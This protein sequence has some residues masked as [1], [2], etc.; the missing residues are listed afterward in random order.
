M[1]ALNDARPV[2]QDLADSTDDTETAFDRRFATARPKLLAVC[3]SVIGADLAEDVVQDTYIR[4][5]DRISQL[6]RPELFEAWLT[7][8]A[9]NEART[10]WR[11]ERRTVNVIP[12]GIVDGSTS[13]DAALIELVDAL[14]IR[15]QMCVALHYG[16]GYTT[17]EI[18]QLLDISPINTRTIL[19]RARRRL[20]R[21]L[22]EESD[23]ATA[24]S[25][26]PR[27]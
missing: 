11:R 22:E 26:E 6:R 15:E 4:A 1:W 8:I 9:F 25:N 21:Q 24:N 2:T 16:H 18:A 7:R 19:F 12:E 3:R 23:A 13:H 20:R 14:P 17:R 5:R 10:W 27:G